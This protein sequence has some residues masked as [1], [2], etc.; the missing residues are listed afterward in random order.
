M[1]GPLRVRRLKKADAFASASVP[2]VVASPARP[3][4]HAWHAP[5]TGRC[6]RSPACTS[7]YLAVGNGRRSCRLQI[8]LRPRRLPHCGGIKVTLGRVQILLQSLQFAVLRLHT[9]SSLVRDG[10]MDPS[11]RGPRPSLLKEL[12]ARAESLRAPGE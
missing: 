6:R 10:P 2:P 5:P 8:Q 11:E 4:A 3:P 12:L 7:R 9:P 1:S